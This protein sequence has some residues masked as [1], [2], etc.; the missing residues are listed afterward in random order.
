ML[1]IN[2]YQTLASST[3][4]LGERD[5]D[6]SVPLLGLFGE[7]GSL[8]SEAKKKQRDPVAYLG[9][10]RTVLEEFGDV[11][12][13]LVSVATRSD[14][15]LDH[16]ALQIKPDI[17]Q[18]SSINS[19]PITFAALQEPEAQI[20][21]ISQPTVQFERRLI[22]LSAEVGLLMVDFDAGRF[23]NNKPALVG[24]LLSVLRALLEAADDAGITLEKAAEGN[25]RKIKDRWPDERV[26]PTPFDA[27]FPKQERFER[28]MMFEIAEVREGDLMVSRLTKDGLAIGD[29]LT[30]NRQGD[31]DYRFHDVFHMAYAAVMGWSPT[32][33][34]LLKRKR[35]SDPLIDETQDGARA[36]LIE[37]GIATWIFN[38][39]QRLEYFENLRALDYSMLKNV[40]EFV[41]GY[42][43]EDCPLWCWEEAILQGYAA[44]RQVKAHRG[45]RLTVDLDKHL[46]QYEKL[47]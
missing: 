29:V 8:L 28:V 2:E 43:S 4:H 18:G 24:R 44:F 21:W 37:E 3:D 7:I 47:K 17:V 33:R 36:I 14:I 39:A 34:R 10:E 20:S 40:R 23:T 35:K 1:T 41:Q 11:L 25:L 13:Y 5:G 9:Y 31:D 15:A 42:E 16:L 38:H 6:L 12:W 45:G 22:R 30:D 32:L 27:T 26:Y 46:L 19:A